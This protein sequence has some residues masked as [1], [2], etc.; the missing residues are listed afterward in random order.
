MKYIIFLLALLIGGNVYCQNCSDGFYPFKAGI[1]WETTN[2]T[3]TN[4]AVSK[5]TSVI[6]SI[7]KSATGFKANISA[8]GEDGKGKETF[9][10][11]YDVECIN[12]VFRMDLKSMMGP[13]QTAAFKDMKDVTIE[14]TG[15]YLETPKSLSI[16][17]TLKQSKMLMTVK[18]N[19]IVMMTME[20]EIYDRKVEAK[21]TITVPAGTYSCYKISYKSRVTSSYAGMPVKTESSTTQWLSQGVGMVKMENYR[22]GKISGYSLLTKYSN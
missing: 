12:N 3:A 5:S 14:F 9:N 20:I 21:E 13:E 2:Y 17:D 6:K 19:D 16:G 11:S 18:N 22:N 4:K 1:S 7:N 8:K 10:T 15:D